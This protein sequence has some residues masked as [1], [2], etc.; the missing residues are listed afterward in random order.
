MFPS[1]V[2]GTP[3]LTELIGTRC[4]QV[5]NRNMS[6]TSSNMSI[7]MDVVSRIVINNR[8]S[9]LSWRFGLSV[10]CSIK[11]CW[12][13][14]CLVYVYHGLIGTRNISF[15]MKNLSSTF[16]IYIF[17]RL[18]IRSARNALMVRGYHNWD[19][20]SKPL[21]TSSPLLNPSQQNITK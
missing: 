18:W 9:V 4:G 19:I 21:L 14:A 20:F 12:L 11:W 2:K 1:T 5:C 15:T 8:S 10:P 13:H 7:Y 6:K 17:Y 16:S 3:F